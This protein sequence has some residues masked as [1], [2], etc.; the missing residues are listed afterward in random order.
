MG[1]FIAK[2]GYRSPFLKYDTLELN[3]EWPITSLR[4]KYYQ[5]GLEWTNP[6]K[7]YGSF[8]WNLSSAK[9]PTYKNI[10]SQLSSVGC[11]LYK[12]SDKYEIQLGYRKPFLHEDI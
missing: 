2:L 11:G 7:N 3:L 10:D 9:E 1:N 12:D 4:K 6:I 8:S 5:A